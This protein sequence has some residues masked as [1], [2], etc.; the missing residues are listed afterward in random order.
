MSILNKLPMFGNGNYEPNFKV[1]FQSGQQGLEDVVA[2]A[3]SQR[4]G[5]F[6]LA[7][8]ELPGPAAKLQVYLK[9]GFY[10][11]GGDAG[12]KLEAR[13]APSPNQKLKLDIGAFGTDFNARK[14]ID[15]VYHLTSPHLLPSYAH[16]GVTTSPAGNEGGIEI[17]SFVAYGNKLTPK[18]V[19]D[20]VTAF[21]KALEIAVNSVYQSARKPSPKLILTLETGNQIQR[22]TPKPIG[23][24][25]SAQPK[26]HSTE[27]GEKSTEDNPKPSLETLTSNVTFANIGG[28]QNVKE[29][30]QDFL[31]AIKNPAEARM[32]GYTP[33]KGW[34]LYGPPGT[35]KTLFGRALAGETGAE[36]IYFNASDALQMYVGESTKALKATFEGAQKRASETKKPVIL[37]I[38]EIDSIFPKRGTAHDVKTDLV[39]LFNQYMDGFESRR[40]PNVYVVAA[41]NRLNEM[42]ESATRAGRFVQVEVTLPDLEARAAI[43]RVTKR[44]LEQ[45]A[46]TQ[47]FVP[48]IDYATLASQTERFSGADIAAIMR[49]ARQR[50]FRKA[51][52]AGEESIIPTLAGDLEAEIANYRKQNRKGEGK[53]KLGFST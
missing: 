32:H 26:G 51:K 42:D 45:E 39:N 22:I 2:L 19:N 11:M 35:G 12:Y 23:A 50:A 33:S 15:D 44:A 43:F 38:D 9:P 7:E 36:F 17:S 52:T 31:L 29:Q 3:T 6:V 48:G 40:I 14:I 49:E 27:V 37:F 4:S 28:Y 41:T 24:A 8:A 13:L 16:I 47:L 21:A 25:T 34:L 10:S 53:G 30:L 20:A 46:G 5:T 18:E 1:E